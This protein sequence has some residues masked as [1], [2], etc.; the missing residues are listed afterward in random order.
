MLG[1]VGQRHVW[2]ALS[3]HEM[4]CDQALE[5]DG[6][7]RVAQTVLQRPEHLSD[8]RLT[9]VCCDQNMLDVFRLWGRGLVAVMSS[10]SGPPQP[11]RACVY[12]RAEGE[13]GG[14]P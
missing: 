8:A 5:Y 3:H 10:V 6:P 2:R 13:G 14:V 11:I 12:I 4:D 7:C 1:K 9:R